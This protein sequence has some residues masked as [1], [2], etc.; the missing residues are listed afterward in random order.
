MSSEAERE[1]I[2]ACYASSEA[3]RERIQV[4]HT[5]SEAERQR[6]RASATSKLLMHVTQQSHAQLLADPQ[7]LSLEQKKT[8]D[9]FI[10]RY[11]AGEPL[12]YL[13]GKQAFWTMDLIVTQDTLIPRPETECLIDWCLQAINGSVLRVADLGTGTGA[14]AIAIALEKPTWMIDATDISE[15]TLLIAKQNAK[16]YACNHIHFYQGHWCDALPHEKY[17]LI[18]SNPPYIADN[19]PHL[20]ELTHEPQNA[21]ISGQKGLNAITIITKSA[22]EFLK[23]GGVLVIEHGFDQANYVFRLF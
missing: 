21:L 1:R 17:D 6:E 23:S 12:A 7:P 19:D 11:D 20:K 3:E 8:L 5:S 13:T 4:C 14:I 18:I 2:Q 10:K 9:A 22:S 15:K 16:A